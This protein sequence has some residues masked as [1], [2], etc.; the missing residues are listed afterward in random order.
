M[1]STGSHKEIGPKI[2]ARIAKE[3]LGV[4]GR[5]GHRAPRVSAGGYDG[6]RKKHQTENDPNRAVERSCIDGKLSF[7]KCVSHGILLRAPLAFNDRS[8]SPERRGDK[9]LDHGIV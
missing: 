5:R 4:L 2:L 3:T 1:K 9:C 6:Q 8:F 7:R